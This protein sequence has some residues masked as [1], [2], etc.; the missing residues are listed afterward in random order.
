MAHL[1]QQQL[2]MVEASP[3]TGPLFQE[4]VVLGDDGLSLAFPVGSLVPQIEGGNSFEIVVLRVEER[5]VLVAV[6]SEAWHKKAA[7]RKLPQGAL[8]KPLL[9]ACQ[10]C[11]AENRLEG[12]EGSS[13]DVWLGWL[14]PDLH[15]CVDF[16]SGTTSTLA[17][18]TRRP[19]THVFHLQRL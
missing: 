1:H 6:P 16:T 8:T 10:A 12:I 3:P 15:S 18:W 9:V 7:S 2:R 4:E 11:T 14:N 5:G 19:L 13:V 17:S